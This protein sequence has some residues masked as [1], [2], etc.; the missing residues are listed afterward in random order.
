MIANATGDEPPPVSRY[1]TMPSGPLDGLLMR[2]AFMRG[3]LDGLEDPGS[4]DPWRTISGGPWVVA[5]F[6]RPGR[7]DAA[8]S[9][10]EPRGGSSQEVWLHAVDA[11][12]L[13][14]DLGRGQ[15]AW[16]SIKRGRD[17][18]AVHGLAGLRKREPPR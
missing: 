5:A 4:F 1:S 7:L 11:V 8:M 15:E 9:I 3:R 16:A 2:L 17:L 10:Y 13:M 14:L 6:V 18:I 12:D